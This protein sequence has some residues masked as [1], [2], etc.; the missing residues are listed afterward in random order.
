MGRRKEREKPTTVVYEEPQDGHGT[1]SS[2]RFR[3]RLDEETVGYFTEVKTHFDSLEDAEEKSLLV[4]NVLEEAVGKELKVATDAGCSRILEAF[5]G[6]ADAAHLGAFTSVFLEGEAWGTLATN[7]FGSHVAERLLE[8]IGEQLDCSS[9][10]PEAGEQLLPVLQKLTAKTAEFLYDLITDRYGS[11]VVRRLLCVL[12]GHDVTPLQADGQQASKHKPQKGKAVGLAAKLV[13]ATQPLQTEPAR[14]PD[15][16]G[17]LSQA[18]LGG[19]YDAGTLQEMASHPNAGPFL[20]TL[21]KACAQDEASL[22]RLIPR[23][24]GQGADAAVGSL[25]GLEAEE[26]QGLMRERTSSH[27]MEVVFQVAP[28]ALLDDLYARVLKGSLAGLA[29]HPS[30]NFVVQAAAAAATKTPQVKQLLGEL[31]DSFRELLKQRRSGVVAALLAA[32]G[33]TGTGQAEA[34]KALANALMAGQPDRKA[35]APALLTMDSSVELGHS[36]ESGKYARLSTLGCAMLSML[37]K[38]PA[39][40]CSQYL[41]SLAGLTD[42]QV[43]HAGMD[44]GGSRVLEAYLSSGATQKTKRRLLRKLKGAY[45]LLAEQPGGNFVV[46][47]CYEFANLKEKE[48]IT[49]ELA[50]AESRLMTTPRGAKLLQRC[51]V[52]AYKRSSTD[53]R[54]K[55]QAADTTRQEFD[56]LFGEHPANGR[57]DAEQAAAGDDVPVVGKPKRESVVLPKRLIAELHGSSLS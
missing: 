3:H 5:L 31:K 51:G 42:K 53:W 2:D 19:D 32:C 22:Q 10:D 45:G 37:L 1:A 54:T 15:L 57:P 16:L 18:I 8:V 28:P 29:L 55:T 41:E 12:C 52:Q 48:I 20:Q 11:H 21:L 40:A 7:P 44:G 23:L 26:L 24:L 34:C 9:R 50:H 43:I 13:S 56:A 27:L 6:S 38:Y 25:A 49:A 47:K 36:S 33:R 39:D 4:G 46:E 35:V 14:Y 30:A 17:L